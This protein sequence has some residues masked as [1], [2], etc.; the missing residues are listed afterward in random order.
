MRQCDFCGFQSEENRR[1]CQ[2]CGRPFNNIAPNQTGMPASA[3]PEPVPAS[4]VGAY[5][6]QPQPYPPRNRKK[7]RTIIIAAVALLVVGVVVA[8]QV[9]FRNRLAKVENAIKTGDYEAA[10]MMLDEELATNP[11]MSQVYILYADYYVANEQYADAIDILTEGAKRVDDKKT[12]QKRIDVLQ[13]EYAVRIDADLRQRETEKQARLAER[14]AEQAAEQAE[15]EQAAQAEKEAYIAACETVDW[16]ELARNPEAYKGKQLKI[17][18]EVAQIQKGGWFADGGCRLYEDYTFAQGSF[19]KKEWYVSV[20]VEK[21][22]P[23]ILEDDIVS[24]YGEFTGTTEVTRAFSRNKEDV[25]CL[26]VKYYA[27]AE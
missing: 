2:Q 20:D 10:Q 25:L 5:P 4:P 18:G 24:F 21:S 12:V 13:Q 1:F 27:I 23:R 7:R 17:Q 9:A 11:S 16:T 22:K 15:Q 3:Y 8:S 6:P 26:E 19:Y 14:A